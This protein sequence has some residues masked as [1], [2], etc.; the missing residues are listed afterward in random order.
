MTNSKKSQ[1]AFSMEHKS[2]LEKEEQSKNV[3]MEKPISKNNKKIGRPT[4]HQ[5]IKIL[6]VNIGLTQKQI[7]ELKKENDSLDFPLPSLSQ[8]IVAKM[9][10][11]KIIKN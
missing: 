5:E 6:Q 10:Q 8:Y 7:E 1:Y 4:K 3:V 2:V 11:A 9:K